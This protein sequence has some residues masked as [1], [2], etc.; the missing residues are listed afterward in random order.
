M[1][2]WQKIPS[3]TWHSASTEGQLGGGGVRNP[4]PPRGQF[5]KR[6]EDVCT[7]PRVKAPGTEWLQSFQSECP[8][9]LRPFLKH[10]R[11]A[12]ETCCC[13]QGRWARGP[14]ETQMVVAPEAGRWQLWPW[15]GRASLHPVRL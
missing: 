6:R 8:F 7:R 10:G 3:R 11:A 13:L 4:D 12:E 5:P 2:A 15:A 9:L 1:P 14:E